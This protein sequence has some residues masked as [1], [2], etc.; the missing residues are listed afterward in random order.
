MDT[1]WTPQI[2]VS[3]LLL[4]ISCTMCKPHGNISNELKLWQKSE[5][6]EEHSGSW[7]KF[8]LEFRDKF[9]FQFQ[10]RKMQHHN[11]TLKQSAWHTRVRERNTT[12]RNNATNQAQLKSMFFRSCCF[13]DMGW[14]GS[15]EE[16]QASCTH[17]SHTFSAAFIEGNTTNSF[18]QV[19]YYWRWHVPT[20]N[21]Q[22]SP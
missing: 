17:G 16:I 22:T 4:I 14:T 15:L 20:E 1:S 12:T 19:L 6:T 9:E 21:L 2:L 10:T 8:E 18:V 7:Q 3:I 13:C 11:W 5:R